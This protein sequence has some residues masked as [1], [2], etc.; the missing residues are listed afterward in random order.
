MFSGNA[1]ASRRTGFQHPDLKKP[2]GL[3]RT[4]NWPR[5]DG[6]EDAKQQQLD[7]QPAVRLVPQE[8][9]LSFPQCSARSIERPPLPA[10]HND[11][12]G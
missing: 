4:D 5:R 12:K 8:S 6:G 2:Q 11:N 10:C 9:P 3:N 1:E 7:D